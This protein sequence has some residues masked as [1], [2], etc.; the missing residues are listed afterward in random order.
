MQMI[1]KIVDC[2]RKC[3]HCIKSIPNL[4]QIFSYNLSACTGP[5]QRKREWKT[6]HK[7]ASVLAV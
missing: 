7:F 3:C 4:M 2:M 5:Y 6:F 1:Y